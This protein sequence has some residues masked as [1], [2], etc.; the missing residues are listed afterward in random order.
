MNKY[1]RP[2]TNK[3]YTEILFECGNEGFEGI[4]NLSKIHN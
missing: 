2:A 4:L 3:A 1:S